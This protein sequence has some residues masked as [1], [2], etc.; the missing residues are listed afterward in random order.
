MLS[1]HGMLNCDTRASMF[2]DG[3]CLRKDVEIFE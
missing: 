3:R 2:D 1:W